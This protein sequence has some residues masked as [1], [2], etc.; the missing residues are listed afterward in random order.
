MSKGSKASDQSAGPYDLPVMDVQGK[1]VGRIQVDAGQIDLRVRTRLLKEAVLMYQA[2][3][4]VGTHETKTRS[5]IAASNKKPWRQKGT[6]RARAGTRRSPLWR[7]GGI[8]FGPHPRD[9][10]YAL[11]VKMRQLAIRSAIFAKLRDGEVMVVDGLQAEAPRT[12]VLAGVLKALGITRRC[13][14]GTE[15]L[16]RNLVLSA[17]NIPGVLI[18]PIREFNALDVLASK[19]VLLTRG[20]MDVLLKAGAAKGEVKS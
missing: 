12:K 20:A 5:M 4:R 15:S 14:I 11:P 10:S 17:R 7:G 9:Y 2:N 13:L 8:I 16:D 1:E 3:K 6:G 19:T 18:A